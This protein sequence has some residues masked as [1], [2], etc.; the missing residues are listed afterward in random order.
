MASD[1]FQFRIN[2]EPRDIPNL[3][4]VHKRDCADVMN[5]MINSVFKYMMIFSLAGLALFGVYS[6]FSFIYLMRTETILPQLPWLLPVFIIA[7]AVF[8][9][10]AGTM[11]KWALIIEI[12]LNIAVVIVSVSTFLT[13]LILPFALY[14]AMLNFKLLTVLPVY[15]VLSEQ[16]GFPEFTPLPTKDEITLRKTET[17]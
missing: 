15:R 8:E 17:E 1:K 4:D 16:P 3:D 7:A 11:Q 14:A 12:I 6:F 5:G 2:V 9:F 10:I 13:L